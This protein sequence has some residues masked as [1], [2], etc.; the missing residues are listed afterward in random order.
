MIEIFLEILDV[1][2]AQAL[3]GSF[4]PWNKEL[5]PALQLHQGQKS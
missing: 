3:F 1:D 2:E 4:S 5:L